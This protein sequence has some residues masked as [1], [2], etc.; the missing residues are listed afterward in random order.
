MNDV[1]RAVGG[2]MLGCVSEFVA[3]LRVCVCRVCAPPRGHRGSRPDPADAECGARAA[4]VGRARA[5]TPLLLEPGEAAAF[6]P[7]L[8]SCVDAHL[9]THPA[10]LRASLSSATPSYCMP[11]LLY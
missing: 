9:P 10:M 2:Y 1:F 7:G 5:Q 8:S 11:E 6:L 3:V 4:A